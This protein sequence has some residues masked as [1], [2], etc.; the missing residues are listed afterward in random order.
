[1][2][3]GKKDILYDM[4]FMYKDV[5]NLDE[6]YNLLSP[7][8]PELIE[9]VRNGPEKM[10]KLTILFFSLWLNRLDLSKES[11]PSKYIPFQKSI[12]KHC[13]KLLFGEY[14]TLTDFVLKTIVTYELGDKK[15]E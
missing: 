4:F 11:D 1:M 8:N 2:S 9:R 3:R 7:F 5:D 15:D 6:I 14:T 12:G 10:P 13:K